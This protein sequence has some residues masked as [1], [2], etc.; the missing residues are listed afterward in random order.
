ME[1]DRKNSPTSNFSI[2]GS[3]KVAILTSLILL[4]LLFAFPAI[5]TWTSLNHWINLAKI[6]EWQEA[7]RNTPAAFYLVVGAYLFG[8]LVLFP[9]TILNVAT[10]FTFGPILG[11][12]YALVGWLASAAMTYG[13][14]RMMGCKIVQK[15]APLWLEQLMQEARRHGFMTVLTLRIFPLAPFTIVNILM[16]AWG[17]GFRD[18]FT[19]SI[20]GRIPGLVLL[21]LAGFQ[22]ENFLRQPGVMGVI[23]LGLTLIL[24]PFALSRASKRLLLGGRRQP[25]PSKSPAKS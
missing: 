1:D 23:L 10:V 14:G 12:L 3:R 22:V 8:S 25:D 13:V 24:V 4:V 9:V 11:N 17:I 15:L 21:T 18:F 16:G 20:V 7:V 6:I 19:A 2:P 5:W